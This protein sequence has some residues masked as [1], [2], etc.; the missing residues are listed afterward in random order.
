[1]AK[2]TIKVPKV[3]VSLQSSVVTVSEGSGF[4]YQLSAVGG[5]APYTYTATNKPSWVNVT[6]AGLVTGVVPIGIGGFDYTFDVIA[7][8]SKGAVSA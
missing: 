5:T 4:E 3:P 8:D 6:P 1:M 2:F 7:T